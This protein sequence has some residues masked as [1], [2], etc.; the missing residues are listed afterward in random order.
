MTLM[1]PKTDSISAVCASAIFVFRNRHASEQFVEK[2]WSF[3][4]Q[5]D[6][7]ATTDADSNEQAGAMEATVGPNEGVTVYPTTKQGLALQATLQ[8]TKYWK[9]DELH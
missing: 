3:A 9:D 6:A 7:A 2:G 1:L 4:C 8:G 5:A